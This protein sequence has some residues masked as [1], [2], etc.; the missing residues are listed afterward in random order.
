M[1]T[2]QRQMLSELDARQRPQTLTRL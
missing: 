2:S 1:G